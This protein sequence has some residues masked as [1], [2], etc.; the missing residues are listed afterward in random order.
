[1]LLN[2]DDLLN[3]SISFV[4][5]PATSF[6]RAFFYYGDDFGKPINLIEVV[7]NVS[8]TTAVPEPATWLMLIVGFGVAGAAA[9]RQSICKTA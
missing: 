2:Q 4:A 8:F 3:Q 6:N 9:R 1:M 5:A 7:D